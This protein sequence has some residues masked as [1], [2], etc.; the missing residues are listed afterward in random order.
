MYYK[1][2]WGEGEMLWGEGR[3]LALP[4]LRG[5]RES[6]GKVSDALLM[7]EKCGLPQV[8]IQNTNLKSGIWDL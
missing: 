1:L 7:L 4:L 6:M 5:R 8:H 2:N 3:S